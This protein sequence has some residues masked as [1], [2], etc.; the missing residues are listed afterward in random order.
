VSFVVSAG[1]DGGPAAYPSASPNVLSVGGTTLKL[2]PTNAWSSETVWKDVT[3]V[4][5]AGGGGE[6]GILEQLP[7]GRFTL[8]PVEPVPSYQAGLGLT[9]RGTPDVSYDGDPNT[10]FLVYD[11]YAFGSTTPWVS[12]G[13]TSAG[14]PQWSALI[15]IADQGRAA[16][17]KPSLSNVQSAIYKLPSSDFH[18]ITVGDN[19]LL[20]SLNPGFGLNLGIS[21]NA[22]GPGYDLASGRGS[23][24]ANLVIRDLIAFNGST[25]FTIPRAASSISLSGVVIPFVK[26][27]A[28]VADGG[29]GDVAAAIG[30]TADG[31]DGSSAAANDL[32]SS[33]QPLAVDAGADQTAPQTD[34]LHLSDSAS[35]QFSSDSQDDGAYISHHTHGSH[36]TD[37]DNSDAVLDSVFAEI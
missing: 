33:D 34:S 9:S 3:G 1:D 21:G 13:G 5:S 6:S 30:S 35:L 7:G 20:G 36:G 32:A 26:P 31:G 8:I 17:G 25:A 2:T 16:I 4:I 12:V 27:G 22:A 19:N 23:P 14:A 15:A 37:A 18:D 11:S 28:L 29:F 10:G 24:I